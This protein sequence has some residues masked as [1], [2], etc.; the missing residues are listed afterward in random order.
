MKHILTRLLRFNVAGG[1]FC[2]QAHSRV[3]GGNLP[4]YTIYSQ[5]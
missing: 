4:R 2:P 1:H 5:W 3:E